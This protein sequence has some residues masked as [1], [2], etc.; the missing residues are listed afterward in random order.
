MCSCSCNHRGTGNWY[1]LFVYIIK[2][3]IKMNHVTLFFQKLDVYKL[4]FDYT[5]MHKKCIYHFISYVYNLFSPLRQCGRSKAML[6]RRHFKSGPSNF[7]SKCVALTF[8]FFKFFL[9]LNRVAPS[10][11]IHF[12]EFRSDEVKSHG[13]YEWTTHDPLHHRGQLLSSSS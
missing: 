9:L 7:I 1:S 8:F 13:N 3:R 11:L 5:M 6:F 4:V 12:L 10:L 2:I